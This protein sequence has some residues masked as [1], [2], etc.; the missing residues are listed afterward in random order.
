MD[1]KYL[2]EKIG[3][4]LKSIGDI[5]QKNQIDC[6]FGKL[7]RINT[8]VNNNTLYRYQHKKHVFTLTGKG[9]AAVVIHYSD[10]VYGKDDHYFDG[11][12]M[13]GKFLYGKDVSGKW[14]F[15]PKLLSFDDETMTLVV[16][17]LENDLG[18]YLTSKDWE[19]AM[20][21]VEKIIVAFTSANKFTKN[22]DGFPRYI[23][24]FL[25]PEYEYLTKLTTFDFYKDKKLA[26][27]HDKTKTRLKEF[28]TS[29]KGKYKN[30]FGI[31]DCKLQNLLRRNN[32]QVVFTDVERFSFNYNWF[33]LLGNVYDHFKDQKNHLFYKTFEGIVGKLIRDENDPILA[34]KLFNMGRLNNILIPCT[35]RNIAFMSEIN[36][37]INPAAIINNLQLA[38]QLMSTKIL[39]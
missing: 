12:Y 2:A 6:E 34:L 8:L 17:K 25:N 20:N 4:F 21:V 30:G 33:M 10:T 29:V 22:S 9:I 26:E 32:G 36:N 11:W 37:P 5:G 28:L 27:E 7:V 38:Q 14:N 35:I 3:K 39:F 16:E 18:D 24:N 19:S 23:E 15:F 31:P 13:D 1:P